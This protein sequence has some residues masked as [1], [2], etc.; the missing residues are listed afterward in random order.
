VVSSSQELELHTRRALASLKKKPE[1]NLRHVGI[2]KI[3]AGKWSTTRAFFDGYTKAGL[4]PPHL[5]A[6]KKAGADVLC[7]C[8]TNGGTSPKVEEIAAEVR[9]RFDGVLGIHPHNDSDWRGQRLA[10]SNR[11]SRMC[12][13]A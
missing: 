7:L 1:V 10:A 11:D 8:D 6:A 12:R 2:S 5:E 13:A 3:T 9:K 4:R